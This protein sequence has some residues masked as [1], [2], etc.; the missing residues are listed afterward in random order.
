MPVAHRT[1]RDWVQAMARSKAI[2]L[3][4]HIARDQVSQGPVRDKPSFYVWLTIFVQYPY[5]VSR[6]RQ[7]SKTKRGVVRKRERCTMGTLTFSGLFCNVDSDSG[8]KSRV[9]DP[10]GHVRGPRKNVKFREFLRSIFSTVNH[11]VR[12]LEVCRGVKYHISYWSCGQ[13]L[14]FKLLVALVREVGVLLLAK[15]HYFQSFSIVSGI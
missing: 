6:C 9:R 1:P 14:S 3:K 8:T 12:M 7:G 13:Y 10:L 4:M 5:S 2:L 15:H 11:H